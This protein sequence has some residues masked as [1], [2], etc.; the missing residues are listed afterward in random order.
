MLQITPQILN[1]RL[2]YQSAARKPLTETSATRFLFCARVAIEV[3]FLGAGGPLLIGPEEARRDL[4]M[5]LRQSS[6][7]AFLAFASQE[8][9][10]EPGVF[11]PWNLARFTVA[12]CHKSAP[13]TDGRVCQRWGCG[14]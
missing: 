12:L 6:A 11:R 13:F 10:D 7:A 5:L 3:L 2:G 8:T 4:A 1:W 9:L 14:A